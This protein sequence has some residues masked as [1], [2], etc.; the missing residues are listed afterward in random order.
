M[1]NPALDALN[2][3]EQD[4]KALAVPAV[5]PSGSDVSQPGNWKGGQ[6]ADTTTLTIIST[7]LNIL[8]SISDGSGIGTTI[9]NVSSKLASLLQDRATALKALADN[10]TRQRMWQEHWPLPSA[11]CLL[12]Q[13]PFSCCKRFNRMHKA[14]NLSLMRCRLMLDRPAL[15]FTRSRKNS[16]ASE[17]R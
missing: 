7:A 14:C 3:F 8:Y 9:S 17:R 2:S 6:A 1:A 10:L 5:S 12:M 4:I 13:M 15:I 11:R 16:R